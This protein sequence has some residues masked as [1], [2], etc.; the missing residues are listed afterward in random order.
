VHSAVDIAV[1][2]F[3]DNVRP[4]V[5]LASQ[6]STA[7]LCIATQVALDGTVVFHVKQSEL[8][9][10]ASTIIIMDLFRLIFDADC[11]LECKKMGTSRPF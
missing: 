5:T 6:A 2:N 1:D 4:G 9:L 7:T 3:V 10:P 11:C 8:H